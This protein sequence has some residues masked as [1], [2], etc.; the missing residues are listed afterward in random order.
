[1]KRFTQL[2]I[3][4]DRT[5][6]SS[7]KLEAMVRYVREAPPHDAAWGLYFLSGRKLKRLTNWRV[8]DEAI[9]AETNLPEWLVGASYEAVGDSAEMMSL[10][11][12]REPA[13]ALDESL[14]EVVAKR[15]LPLRTIADPA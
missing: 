15:L 5:T 10:L 7:V 3:E 4:M 14:H 12:P 9:R 6:R 11:Y 2:F 1:M 13:E 8:L